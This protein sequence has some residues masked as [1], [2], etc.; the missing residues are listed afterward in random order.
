[1][2]FGVGHA[3]RYL[4][5]STVGDYA[6]VGVNAQLFDLCQSLINRGARDRRTSFSRVTGPAA[7]CEFAP[8]DPFKHLWTS[9]PVPP[10]VGG[11]RPAQPVR[12]SGWLGDWR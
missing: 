8:D 4:A 11:E 2:V 3:V 9:P 6:D 7:L 5:A 1:M 12:S 10:N